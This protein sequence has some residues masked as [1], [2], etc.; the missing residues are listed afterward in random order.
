MTL[1]YLAECSGEYED[2]R[3]DPVEF[4]DDENY[5]QD[6]ANKYNATVVKVKELLDL[7]AKKYYRTFTALRDIE[8]ENVVLER[9]VD[10]PSFVPKTKEEHAQFG[11]IKA[12]NKVIEARNQQKCKEAEIKFLEQFLQSNPIPDQLKSLV[13]CDLG[14]GSLRIPFHIDIS[15]NVFKVQVKAWA[16]KFLNL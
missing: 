11:K 8:L 7:E 10:K 6:K 4:S 1:Y 14:T 3:Q 12:Q 5:L 16:E 13:S 2:Y 9:L 15:Y